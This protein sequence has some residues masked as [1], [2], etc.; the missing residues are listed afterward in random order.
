MNI[1]PSDIEQI[2]LQHPE[3]AE[4][5]VIG[6]AH[7]EWG[8]SPLALVVKENPE[9]GISSDGLEDWANGKLAGY[10]KLSRLEFRQSLPKNDLGKIL[11][12][13]LR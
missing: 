7:H 13:D 6:V 9:V 11:K 1:Y 8:E 5:A 4:A 2:L 10:Q 12:K 3:V